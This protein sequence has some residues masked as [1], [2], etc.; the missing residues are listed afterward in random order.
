MKK[1]KMEGS[2][3]WMGIFI[4]T[5]LFIMSWIVGIPDKIFY[6]IVLAFLVKI[7]VLLEDIRD[8]K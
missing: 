3:F 8:K 2:R 1:K 6:L 7:I 4:V 5:S